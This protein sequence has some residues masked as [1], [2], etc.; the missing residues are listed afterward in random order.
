MAVTGSSDDPPA[1]VGRTG[2]GSGGPPGRWVLEAVAAASLGSTDSGVGALATMLMDAA[3]A[4]SCCA[5]AVAG[6]GAPRRACPTGWTRVRP[7]TTAVACIAGAGRSTDAG[8]EGRLAGRGRA[9]DGRAG[10]LV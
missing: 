10:R 8:A 9:R 1:S 3:A 5:R 4:G 2:A 7:A 6:A